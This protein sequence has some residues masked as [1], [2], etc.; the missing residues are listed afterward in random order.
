MTTPS[1]KERDG[2]VTTFLLQHALRQP[3]ADI[4]LQPADAAPVEMLFSRKLAKH[5]HAEQPPSRPTR[6]PS[7]V[8]SAEEL[9]PDREALIDPSRK[10][11]VPKRSVRSRALFRR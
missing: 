9:L 1:W 3:I 5:G 4:A 6:K 11:N 8:V 2:F 10:G 7:D